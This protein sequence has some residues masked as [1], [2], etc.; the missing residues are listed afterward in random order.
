MTEPRIY[1]LTG[2]TG[3]GK[4]TALQK[5]SERVHNIGG[6][7]S[8]LTDGKR[9]FLDL[10]SKGFFPM[11]AGSDETNILTVGRFLFSRNSFDKAIEILR[12]GIGK[13]NWLLLDEI[14]PLEL[15]GEGF[16]DVIKEMINANNKEQK[17]LLVVRRSLV[18]DVIGYFNISRSELLIINKASL[19]EER[20]T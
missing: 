6:V 14:G 20:F 9:F 12:N 10:T 18:D 3:E 16:H 8:V 2:E 5:W 19:L 7:L 15:K 13:T 17:I 4:T 1:I 11:E